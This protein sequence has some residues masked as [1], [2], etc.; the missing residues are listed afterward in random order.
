MQSCIKKSAEIVI[1]ENDPGLHWCGSVNQRQKDSSN[2]FKMTFI[3]HR[4]LEV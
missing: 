1:S 4:Q 3:S 2:N